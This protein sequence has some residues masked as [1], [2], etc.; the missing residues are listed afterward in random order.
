MNQ[1]YPEYPSIF[2]RLHDGCSITTFN[3]V[4]AKKIKCR[5][6]FTHFYVHFFTL[7]GEDDSSGLRFSI[8]VLPP[9][10]SFGTAETQSVR[11]GSQLQPK[12]TMLT[13]LFPTSLLPTFSSEPTL[14]FTC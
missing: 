9:R 3:L 11:R 6:I 12:T 1:F 8:L 14:T 5:E 4:F 10:S 13:F 7:D 2:H